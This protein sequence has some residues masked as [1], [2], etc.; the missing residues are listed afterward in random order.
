MGSR[1]RAIPWSALIRAVAV[2]VSI[3][4]LL[5]LLVGRPHPR[6]LLGNAACFV[7][8]LY[9]STIAHELGHALAGRLLGLRVW[10]IVVGSGPTLAKHKVFATELQL[11]SI[12]IGGLTFLH[13]ESQTAVRL[14]YWLSIAA[15]PATTATLLA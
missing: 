2:T 1:P 6:I 8:A 15:G 7:I 5:S 12:P 13:P 3:P 9:L 10:R 4:L 14:R 11:G